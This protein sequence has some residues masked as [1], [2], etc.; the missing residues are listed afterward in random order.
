MIGRAAASA[1]ATLAVA[2]P[3]HAATPLARVGDDDEPAVA[4]AG[5]TALLQRDDHAGVGIYAVPIDASARAQR[6]LHVDTP[7]EDSP[8]VWM[9][10]TP[11]RAAIAIVHGDENG[12]HFIG[13][14]FSGPP[15]GPWPALAPPVTGTPET[16]VPFVPQLDG[17]R[18]FVLEARIGF[19][20]GGVSVI[21]PGG[22]PRVVSRRGERPQFAGERVVY[23]DGERLMVVDPGA[24]PR[25]IGFRS[26]SMDDFDADERHVLWTANGCLLVADLTAPAAEA[27]GPGIC[28]RAALRGR[29]WKTLVARAVLTD[30][31]GR[32]SIVARGYSAVVR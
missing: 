18:L 26:A 24:K 32:R 31:D 9:S 12:T 17:D 29:G 11:E 1:I 14:L 25:P 7:V 6:R 21:A 16:F 2:A 8:S 15:A 10:G 19:D 30:P 27:P 28:A 5:D 4:L 3:G 13:E 23:R 22:T 20:G